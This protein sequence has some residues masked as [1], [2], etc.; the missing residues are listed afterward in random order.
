ML[1]IHTYLPS[2]ETAC[3]KVTFERPT[4][5]EYTW[6]KKEII[7]IIR[8]QQKSVTCHFISRHV[9]LSR[10]NWFVSQKAS[11]WRNGHSFRIFGSR[12]GSRSLCSPSP[13][14][15]SVPD[16]AFPPLGSPAAAE[17]HTAP[18][19]GTGL[20]EA[21]TPATQPASLPL[22]PPPPHF[23]GPPAAWARTGAARG[24]LRRATAC[25]KP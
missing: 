20:S 25:G 7:P 2:W 19:G 23:K 11:G 15:R 24:K 22:S 3:S 13:R 12:L 17:H 16:A 21:H 1:Y 8:W 14:R 9:L 10:G 18:S 6:T 4:C 5:K